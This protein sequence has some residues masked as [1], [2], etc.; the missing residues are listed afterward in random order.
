MRRRW[1]STRTICVA[2]NNRALMSAQAG[3]W[4]GTSAI[5][6]L[7][8][9]RDL[10]P[11]N[12]AA[13]LNL[14]DTQIAARHFAD[15]RHTLHQAL[16]RFHGAPAFLMRQAIALAFEGQIEA[17]QAAIDALSPEARALMAER[18]TAANRTGERLNRKPLAAATGRLRA[19]LPAG[20]RG[21]A[22]LRLARP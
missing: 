21:D 16:A 14:A 2:L 19:V 5:D 11:D 1:R 22:G 17:A 3:R 20:L 7:N 15:A 13:W 8:Q 10:Q 6:A 4:T 18:I 12:P 9:C